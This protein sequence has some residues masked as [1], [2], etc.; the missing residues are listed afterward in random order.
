M[1]ELVKIA[2]TPEIFARLATARS[3]YRDVVTVLDA[4]KD[5][6]RVEFYPDSSLIQKPW[7]GE[8]LP[9]V[10]LDVEVLWSSANN[11]YVTGKVLAHDEDR[12]VFRFT[13]GERKGDYQSDTC[14]FSVGVN[15]L[16]NFRPIRTPEQI[17]KAERRKDC[18]KMHG[19]YLD[20]PESNISDFV[21]ALYDAGYR[22]TDV[23]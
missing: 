21:E 5:R 1:L 6:A 4:S 15:Q 18:D 2:V 8:G 10:G 7:N 13:S 9:P 14:H 12:A 16:P 19:M 20:L 22:K 11:T 17:A 23:Q 3:S